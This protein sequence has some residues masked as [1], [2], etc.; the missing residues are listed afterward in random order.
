MLVNAYFLSYKVA[1]STPAKEVQ[2]NMLVRYRL[3]AIVV[4]LQA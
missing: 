1:S 2:M 4:P 3:H